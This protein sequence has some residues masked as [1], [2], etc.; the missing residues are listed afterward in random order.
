MGLRFAIAGGLAV[1]ICAVSSAAWA[2]K[3]SLK[4]ALGLAYQTNP[5]LDGARAALRALDETVAQADAGW[6]PSINLTGSYGIEH[7]TIDGIA[8]PFDSRPIVGQA[9]VTMPIFRGGRTFA[10]VGRAISTVRSGRAQ[11]T[12]IE[13]QVLLAAATVYMDVVRDSTNLRYHNEN[14]SMLQQVL[15]AVRTQFAGGAVTK[16][17]VSEAESR[18]ARARVDAANAQRLLAASRAAFN[19]IIGRPVEMLE[20]TP[21]LPRL[22]KS[23]TEAQDIALKLN[24]EVLQANANARAAD[25]AV[26]DAAGAL[27]PQ[28]SVT[29]QYQYLKDAGGTNIFATKKPQQILSVEGQIT[30]PIYQGGADEANV[31]RAKELRQQATTAIAVAQRNATQGVD[32]AWE[33]SLSTEAALAASQSQLNSALSALDGVK[34][35]QKAGERSVLDVLNAQAEVLAS[36]VGVVNARHDQVIV[37]YQLLR[38]TGQLT[39]RSLGLNVPLYDPRVHYEDDAHAW[40]GL[41][42]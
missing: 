32:T 14:V 35:E 28:I 34:Q 33:A 21:A 26:D 39:A 4:D 13:G 10:E 30:V 7:A 2:E 25:Y 1:A 37:A 17:D 29:G 38:S 16:T 9:T 12:A 11:L 18:L 40:F 3:L 42:N 8:S 27:L 23:Q 19:N 5:N 6:R 31:R 24:P 20:D 15:E 36:Q 22:P 41:G